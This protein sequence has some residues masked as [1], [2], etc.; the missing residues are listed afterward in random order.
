MNA[1]I[2]QLLMSCVTPV[3]YFTF[4]KVHPIIIEAFTKEQRVKKGKI[5]SYF[6]LFFPSF[7]LSFFHRRQYIYAL[8]NNG[9]ILHMNRFVAG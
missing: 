2:M 7:F 1:Y 5:I 9:P 6:I 8:S 4:S 3:L